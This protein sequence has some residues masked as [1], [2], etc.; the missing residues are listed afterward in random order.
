M[1][2]FEELTLPGERG[3]LVLDRLALS[4]GLPAAVV[5]DNGPEF[6]GHVLDQWAHA[7]GVTLAFIE[8]RKQV[9]NAIAE[10]F[11]G[12]LRG[13]VPLTRAGS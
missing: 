5:C 6:S 8:P 4:R 2:E 11:N 13:S 3:V 10:S 1:P 12:R 9:Q 7:C